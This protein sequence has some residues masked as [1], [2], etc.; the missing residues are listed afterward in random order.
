MIMQDKEEVTA[1]RMTGRDLVCQWTLDS[2]A[3]EEGQ[4]Q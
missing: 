4:K 2:Q 3:G 1:R